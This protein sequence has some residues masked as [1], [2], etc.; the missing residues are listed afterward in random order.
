MTKEKRYERE[1]GAKQG[2]AFGL[3][4]EGEAEMGRVERKGERREK[5]KVKAKKEGRKRARKR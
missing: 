4:T 2:M 1:L 3:C 5:E